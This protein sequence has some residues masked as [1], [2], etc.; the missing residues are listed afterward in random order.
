[1]EDILAKSERE[2]EREREGVCVCVCVCEIE[3]EELRNKEKERKTYGQVAET[4][5]TNKS[6]ATDS[7]KLQVANF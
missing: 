6:R 5:S 1:M 7:T 2:K 4:I 3:R